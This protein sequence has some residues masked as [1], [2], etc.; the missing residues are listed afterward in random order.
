MLAIEAIRTDI[1]RVLREAGHD[2]VLVHLVLSPAWT[3]DWLSE[4][5]R[6]KLGGSPRTREVS[7]FG[8]TAR[9]ASWVCKACREPFD[10]FKPL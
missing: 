8:S 6:R 9:K 10:A 5:A 2:D 4:P 3:T 7:R 1:E